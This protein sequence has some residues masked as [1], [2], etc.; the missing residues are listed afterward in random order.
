V[1]DSL[2]VRFDAPVASIKPGGV[3]LE[4]KRDTLWVPLRGVASLQPANDCDPLKYWIPFTIQPDSTYRLTIDSAAVTSVY[5]L[6]NDLLS[7]ELKVKGL[8]EYANVFFKVNV[9]DGAFAE[10]LSGSEKVERTATV[11]GGAFEFTNVNPGTYYMRLTI[12]ANGNGKWDT[13]NYANHL[14]P[15]EVYYYPKQLKLRRNWDLDENWNIYQTALDLQKPESIKHNKPE[16]AK[17][18]IEKKT[19]KREGDEEEEDEFST[20]INNTYTGNKYN[21]A[22][23]KR[24]NL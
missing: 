21:D 1:R 24:P 9:R 8:E 12:D 15:E 22:K 18:K 23:R 6:H 14:Q 10:L 16:Q 7:K 13:G 3:R 17:N 20:G 19:N 11:N 2:I 4:M 5:G